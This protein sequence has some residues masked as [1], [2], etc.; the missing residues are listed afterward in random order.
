MPNLFGIIGN[1]LGHSFSP[2]YFNAKFKCLN[3]PFEYKK[4]ELQHIEDFSE[5][6]QNQNLIGLN[7][8]IPFKEKIIPFLNEISPE[9]QNVGSVNTILF[10][11]NKTIGYNTDVIGFEK[12]LETIGLK[13][14]SKCL[15]LGS[16]GASKAVKY[17]LEKNQMEYLLVSRKPTFGFSYGKLN[18]KIIQ[19]Y[20]T[21]INTT[22]LGMWPNVEEKPDIPYQFLNPKNILIDLIYKPR[23]T[24]FLSEGLN[25][26]CRIK[27]G[28]EMLVNQAEAA[29]KIWQQAIAKTD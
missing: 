22:P 12:M 20:T 13:S 14:I 21:I 9:A 15:I 1:P 28:Y 17:V 16:G 7:V 25:R 10:A 26:G 29:W 23:T 2:D 18:K 5:L 8:T 24:A 4:F 11:E 3:L 27:N 6:A 19:E